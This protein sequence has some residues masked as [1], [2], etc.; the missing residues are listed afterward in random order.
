MKKI[1]L[2]LLVISLVVV[3]CSSKEIEKEEKKEELV[4]DEEYTVKKEDGVISASLMM[5]EG[6]KVPVVLII[7]GSGPI[8]KNGF[9]NEYIM[10]ADLLK[11]EGIATVS[12]DKIGAGESLVDNLNE[13]DITIDTFVNDAELLIDNINSDSRFSNV[14][15][16]GHSQGS[17]IAVLVAKDKD[18]DGIISL[19]GAGRVLD[20][21]L[22]EQLKRN[23]NNTDKILAE[24]QAIM[25]ELAKGKKVEKIPSYYG[26]L[27][28]DDVQNLMISWLQLDPS[29][30]YASL[31]IPVLIIQGANDIQVSVEDA[32][33]L[34]NASKNSTLVIL[35]HMSHVL[36]DTDDKNDMTVYKDKEKPINKQ[37]IEEMVKFIKK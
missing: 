16:A 37:M 10:M 33:M 1:I 26:A 22:I 32:K 31:D 13:S 35:D 6:D 21:V 25:D 23:P 29:K 12:Y 3:S 34:D 19:A 18:V 36:K 5:P 9:V 11:K 27:F 8:Q 7:G 28:R 2:L 15:I 20:E 4:W 17:L 30:E 24:G 14:Y